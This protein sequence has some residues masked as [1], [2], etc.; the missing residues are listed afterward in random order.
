MEVRHSFEVR[1]LSP[2]ESCCS[3]SEP[4][5][6]PHLEPGLVP[7][8]L[9][10]QLLPMHLLYLPQGALVSGLQWGVGKPQGQW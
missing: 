3:P 8:L 4:K 10:L 6:P 9:L 7:P 2:S 1:I 5:L